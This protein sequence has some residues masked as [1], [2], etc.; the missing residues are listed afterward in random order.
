MS[1]FR[2]GCEI[3]DVFCTG[4]SLL[5]IKPGSGTGG[6]LGGEVGRLIKGGGD[7]DGAGGGK[8]GAKGGG[9]GGRG[10]ST[11]GGNLSCNDESRV[12]G[13]VGDEGGGEGMVGDEG[14]GVDLRCADC[15]SSDKV[16]AAGIFC[17]AAWV[18]LITGG[19]GGGGG[20]GGPPVAAT[21]CPVDKGGA[22]GGGGTDPFLSFF[23]PPPL[24]EL[25]SKSV[26]NL[27]NKG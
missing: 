19:G 9:G 15:R 1:V 5:G 22:G 10:A 8:L 14:G 3:E 4:V 6:L 16:G 25:A 7:K 17:N 2:G 18:V 24:I 13:M 11:G 27:S 20:G 21:D 23:P 26:S 12:G